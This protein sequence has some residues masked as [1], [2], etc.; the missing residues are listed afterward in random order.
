[1]S[2]ITEDTN[3]RE[4]RNSSLHLLKDLLSPTEISSLSNDSKLLYKALDKSIQSHIKSIADHYD[5]L[6]AKK[7]Q[8]IELLTNKID[9]LHI[10]NT[11]LQDRLTK[12]EYEH[13][14]TAQYERRDT[15]IFSGNVL[16]NEHEEENTTEVIVNTLNSHLKVPIT[17]NDISIA[18]RLGR[19]RSDFSRPIIVKL[20]SRSKRSQIVRARIALPKPSAQNSPVLHINES[21]TP[22]RRNLFYKARQLKKKHANLIKTLYTQDG[23][24]VVKLTATNDRKYTISNEKEMLDFLEVSPILKDTYNTF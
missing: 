24:I 22:I 11:K 17:Q 5:T 4:T 21:L 8:E 18:H 2:P 9:D 13:D 19:T 6:I 7:E 16:P 20:I 1:M 10:A 23:K 14:E 15:L 3:R 12:L